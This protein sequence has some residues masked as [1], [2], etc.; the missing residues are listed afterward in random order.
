VTVLRLHMP[1]RGSHTA[2]DALACYWL[3]IAVTL[4]RQWLQRLG[5]AVETWRWVSTDL[6]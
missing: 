6:I 4:R 5:T 2:L 3:C 1:Q